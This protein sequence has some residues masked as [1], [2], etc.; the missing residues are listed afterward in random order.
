MRTGA[1]ARRLSER[2]WLRPVRRALK[3]MYVWAVVFVCGAGSGLAA[4]EVISAEFADPTRR[5][6]HAVLGD[7]V[8]YSTLVLRSRGASSSLLN[9]AVVKDVVVRVRLPLDHVFEDLTPRLV[10]ITGDGSPEVMVVE[11]DVARGAQLAI[12]DAD[13]EKLAETPHIG[14][15][16]RWLAP[17]GAADLDG[18]GHIEVAYIDRPHLAKTLRVWRYKDGQLQ[19]VAELRGL[20]NHAIGQDFI[21]SGIRDCGAGPELV[22][23]D[24]GWT[25]VMAT[26][27]V[28]GELTSAGI[29]QFTTQQAFADVLACH[30]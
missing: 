10:D 29:T 8:E 12:Y 14:R 19:E 1:K 18:D 30:H 2:L 28:A 21:T 20:T 25:Q 26:R 5:Y 7:D 15:T 4:N 11:T 9:H 16:H 6:G 17:I 13:G 23:V 3:A 27:L 22:T 24:A